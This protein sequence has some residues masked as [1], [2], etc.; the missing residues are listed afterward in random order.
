MGG[1]VHGLF[2]ADGFRRHWL[3]GLGAWSSSL[4]YAE[5]VETTLDAFAEQ[6]EEDLDRLWELARPLGVN[7]DA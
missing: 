7:L 4:H 5:R 2:A 1:Y 3:E 6:L